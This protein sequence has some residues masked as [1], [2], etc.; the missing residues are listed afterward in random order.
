MCRSV[1]RLDGAWGKKQIWCSRVRIWGLSEANVLFWKKCLW[2]C[3]DFLTPAVI[4]RP[5]NSAPVPL[6]TPL[7][8]CKTIGKISENKQIFKSERHE[9]LFHEHLQFSKTIRLDLA[10]TANKGCWRPGTPERGLGWGAVKS[11]EQWKFMKSKKVVTNY[12]GYCS[13]TMLTSKIVK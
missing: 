8:L 3:C 11:W 6:V 13:T 2:H 12:A 1:T 5:G 9:L 4:R 10:Q 7:V